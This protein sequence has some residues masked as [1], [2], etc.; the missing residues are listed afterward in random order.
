MRDVSTGK[1]QVQATAIARY[2]GIKAC[3]M[4]I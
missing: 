4:F 3:D 1:T 2:F